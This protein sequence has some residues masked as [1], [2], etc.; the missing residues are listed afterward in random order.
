MRLSEVMGDANPKK[1]SSAIL[2][3]LEKAE[4]KDWATADSDERCPICLD[5]VRMSK[6]SSAQILTSLPVLSD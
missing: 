1:T 2:E 3:S 5:D 4:Y 6:F